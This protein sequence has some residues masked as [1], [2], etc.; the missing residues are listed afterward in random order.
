MNRQSGCR[1]LVLIVVASIVLYALPVLG[2]GEG[3]GGQRGGGR[4][5]AQVFPEAPPIGFFGSY[6]VAADKMDPSK[7][8]IIGAWRI[9]FAKSDPSLKAAGR[10]KDTG[11]TIYTAVDGGIRTETFLYWPPT[12]VDYKTIFTDDGREYW[13]KLDG[14]NIYKDPQG[15][16]GLGQTVGMWLVDRNTLFRERMTKGVIDERVMYRV[17][18]DGKTLVWTGFNSDGSSGHN[19]WDRI[20]LKR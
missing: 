8:P 10:F 3:R 5:P 15:P 13:F 2:Q 6:R 17:S 14:K 18:P 9:N 7:L 12:K 16:N 1:V 4:G 11:T 20:D 19:V